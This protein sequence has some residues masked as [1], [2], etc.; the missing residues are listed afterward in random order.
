ME[1][2]RGVRTR[3]FSPDGV[4]ANEQKLEIHGVTFV[5][6]IIDGRVEG[7]S[8]IDMNMTNRR[9]DTTSS[10]AIP[11]PIFGFLDTARVGH[12]AGSVYRRMSH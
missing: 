8:V 10:D 4:C 7:R 2:T 6:G 3:Q 5:Q 11:H 9:G 1:D 12:P